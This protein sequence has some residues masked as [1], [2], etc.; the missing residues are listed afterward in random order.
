M[1]FRFG[2]ISIKLSFSFV[3]LIV[4]MTLVCDEKIVFCSVLSSFIHECGHLFFMYFSDD[5]PSTIEFTLFG[6]RISKGES[7]SV[8]YKSEMLTALGGIIFNCVFSLI[9]FIAYKLSGR[10]ELIIISIVNA[11]VAAVNAF[12]V[13]S[14]DSGRAVRC[15]LKYKEADEACLTLI[16]YMFTVVFVSASVIYTAL[17]SV[18]ISLIAVNLYLIFITVIKK[19]S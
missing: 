16:S 2:N 1:I 3:A 6:M 5:K 17:F 14:L 7:C 18:N 19:W 12:P 11:A 13:S 4:T 10:H 8:S 15:F 9:F